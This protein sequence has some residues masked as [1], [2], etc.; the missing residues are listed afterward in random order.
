MFNRRLLTKALGPLAIALMVPT[1][2]VLPTAHTAAAA[3]TPP[4]TVHIA[5]GPYLDYEPWVVAKD[6][7]FDKEFGINLQITEVPNSETAYLDL[8]RGDIQVAYDCIACAFSAIP[9]FPQLREFMITNQFTGFQAIGRKGQA[10][11]F[12]GL[13]ASGLSQ[14]QAK[15]R[16][17]DSWKG[18][19][20]DIVSATFKALVKGAL[21][22][23]GLPLTAVHIDTFSNDSEAALA[24][25]RGVGNFYTGSLPEEAELLLNRHGAYVDVGGDTVFG[26]GALWYSTMS[27]TQAWLTHNRSTVLDLMAVWYRTTQ[28]LA[29]E[30]AK[31]VP[32]LQRTINQASGTTFSVTELT[33]ILQRHFLIY[34]TVS[35]AKQVTY[36]P[37][38]PSDWVRQASFYAR[39]NAPTLPHGYNFRVNYVC[40]SY[41]NMFLHDTTLVNRVTAAS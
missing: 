38:N 34:N 16:I 8:R 19:T 10:L 18:K 14:S 35:E 25:E 23:E 11:T 24:F 22:S 7:G 31:A 37:T 41:F 30:P 12:A 33:N 9:H 26:P 17:V 4:T 27:S 36:N 5:I 28:A 2:G 40:T 13:T 20:F 15:K 6:L 1:T 32:I 3:S 29:T 39:E 21:A